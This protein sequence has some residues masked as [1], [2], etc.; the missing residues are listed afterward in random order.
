MKNF[1]ATVLPGSADTEGDIYPK[2]FL[3]PPKFCCAQKNVF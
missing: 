3:A 2:K 1:L